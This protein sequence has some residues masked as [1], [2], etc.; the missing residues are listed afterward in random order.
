MKR[1]WTERVREVEELA[2]QYEKHPFSLVYRPKLAK[3]YQPPSVWR[4]YPRQTL[5]FNFAK[6]C[7]EDVHIFAL[8]TIIE[9]T[10]RRIYLVTT[11]TEFWFYYM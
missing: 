1:K 10:E 9:E 11:Y 2:S 3:P 6:T 7:K 5:A 8:E 4:L